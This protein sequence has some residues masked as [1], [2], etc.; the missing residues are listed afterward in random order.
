[1]NVRFY[2]GL[3]IIDPEY[4]QSERKNQGGKIWKQ[5]VNGPLLHVG[6]ITLILLIYSEGII[7]NF[8]HA[9]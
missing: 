2:I 7:N 4:Y 5:L 6:D 3:V 8:D 9:L 1:M